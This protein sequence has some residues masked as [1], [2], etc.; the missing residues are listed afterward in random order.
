MTEMSSVIPLV[1]T[2]TLRQYI[3][4]L[5]KMSKKTNI[6]EQRKKACWEDSESGIVCKHCGQLNEVLGDDDD[7]EKYD[8]RCGACLGQL[9]L[10]YI[11]IKGQIIKPK[12]IDEMCRWY[13]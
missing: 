7:L 4:Q 10:M 3:Q 12:I 8:L 13:V 11:Y 2:K 1:K 6:L 5:V 9:D